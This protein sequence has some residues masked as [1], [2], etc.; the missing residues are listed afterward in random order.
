[1]GAVKE[2]TITAEIMSIITEGFANVLIEKAKDKQVSLFKPFK[3]V[4]DEFSIIE[5]SKNIP[6]TIVSF[7]NEFDVDEKVINDVWN[8][9]SE[10]N[11][12]PVGNIWEFIYAED[13]KYFESSQ[14]IMADVEEFEA[15]LRI[16]IPDRIGFL[17]EIEEREVPVKELIAFEGNALGREIYERVVKEFM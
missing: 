7:V 1:M 9:A 2:H 4:N 11:I 15:Y 12:L 8:K 17:R 6:E 14:V 16:A 10:K 3:G 13:G 5:G